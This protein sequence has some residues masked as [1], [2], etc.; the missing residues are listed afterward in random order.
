MCCIYCTVLY[1]EVLAIH[2]HR[3]QARLRWALQLQDTV[4]TP[5]REGDTLVI[6]LDKV[7]QD[8]CDYTQQ[9]LQ[10]CSHATTNP[11]IIASTHTDKL[12]SLQ[13]AIEYALLLNMPYK[14]VTNVQ[15]SS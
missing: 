11:V 6:H 4:N 5:A 13:L 9:Y 8:M 15:F 3:H 2:R 14:P 10:R 7:R 12:R 1:R